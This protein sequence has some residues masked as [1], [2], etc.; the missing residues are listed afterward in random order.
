MNVNLGDNAP[1]TVITIVAPAQAGA[2][3]AC[4]SAQAHVMGTSLRWCDGGF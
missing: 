1:V 3:L 2:Y 4:R